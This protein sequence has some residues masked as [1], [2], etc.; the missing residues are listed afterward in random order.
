MSEHP[1]TD[2]IP[3]YHQFFNPVLGALHALGGSGTVDEIAEKAAAALNLAPGVV[4]VPHGD[5]GQTEVEYRIA[6]AR[7]YLKKVGLL[8]NSSRGVWTLTALGRSTTTVDP[9]A[10]RRTVRGTRAKK[11]EP[12]VS[13]DFDAQGPEVQGIEVEEDWRATSLRAL[14]AM[15]P[16]AFERLCQRLLRES[17]FIEVVVTGRSGDGGIDGRGILRLN[18]LISF[19]VMFQSKKYADAVGAPIVRDFRGALMGRADKGLILTTGR[20]TQDAQREA[21]RDGATPIDLIDGTLLVEKLRELKM[22]ITTQ[23]IE[24]VVVDEGWFA[25]V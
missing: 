5:S 17:G 12:E 22:G 23:V 13:A 1:M 3:R 6:W 8:D 16:A 2:A 9:G 24:R 4:D 14:K 18:G 19:T 20:F 11:R 10:V 7:S 15:E 21:V 25:T